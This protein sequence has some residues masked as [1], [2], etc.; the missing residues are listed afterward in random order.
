MKTPNTSPVSSSSPKSRLHRN[1]ELT[2]R[3]SPSPPS[4]TT[5]S[6]ESIECNSP[7]RRKSS[8]PADGRRHKIT[9]DP[10]FTRHQ[11]W[12]SSSSSS[13]TTAKRDSG[14]L[15]DHIT[16]DRIIEQL[17]VN[18]KE[19]HNKSSSI[20]SQMGSRGFEN[21]ATSSTASNGFKEND[22]PIIGGSTRFSGRFIAPGESSPSS[23]KNGSNSAV[24][25]GENAKSL[26]SRRNSCSFSNSL[27][28]ESDYG[29]MGTTSRKAGKEVPSRYTSD[30][31]SRRAARRGTSDSN[32]ANLDGDSS[33]LKRF[34][35]KTA[36][37]RAN[38]LTG[39][40]SSKSQ[41]ALSPARSESPAMSVESMDKTM[42]FSSLKHPIGPTKAKGVEKFLSL[43]F[44]LFKSKKL[45]GFGSSPVGFG[46]N[47]EV[48][49][50]LR[51][52][53]NRFIQWRFAN[54][55]AQA[56]NENISHQAESNLM[57]AWDGLTKLQ[58]SVLKKKIQFAREKLDMKIT[59]VLYSQMKLLEAWGGMERQHVSAI[60]A[61]KECLHSVVCRVP[62][63]EG[64]RVNM[65]ST[66]IAIRHASDL[67]ASIKS[68]LTTFSSSVDKTA[69]MLSELAKIVAQEKQI[70]E[71]FYDLFQ[72]ISIFELQERSMKCNV[73]QLEDWQRK[74]LLAG[75]TS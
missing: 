68:M 3:F 61:T 60:T 30:V 11:L 27:D 52:L 17:N 25:T 40:K 19:R 66:S 12:P 74:Y 34:N 13:S 22:R 33:V 53:H 37:K 75:I 71:E 56:V 42:L 49:H 26:S 58:H 44:D 10:G 23:K 6:L 73:F 65:Q 57:R 43:G 67:T 1:R 24:F 70:L 4:A 31:T 5:P 48:V 59:F 54:A 2:S 69:T 50:Q 20:F 18:E 36:I 63:L 7:I 46:I 39:Y 32:I 72:T 64:A 16:E 47:S 35:L 29:D 45:S 55:R 41:W 14:T 21:C 38:S 28:L 51:M 9:E 62:L 15:A 8:S